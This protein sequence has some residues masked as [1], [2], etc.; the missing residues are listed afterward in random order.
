MTARIDALFSALMTR[1]GSDLH[2]G[3]GVP[4]QARIRGKLVALRS[5][6]VEEEEMKLLL[7]EILTPEQRHRLQEDLELDF[8]Y[9]LT[10]DGGAVE[11]RFR[12]NYFYK[13]TGPA[14]VFRPPPRIA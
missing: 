5:S 10:G 13:H 1:K 4:P 2:L 11:A 3:C 9:A 8:A 12:A 6:D 14:A 7:E